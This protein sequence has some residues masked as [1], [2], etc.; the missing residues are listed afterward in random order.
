MRS[1]FI[2]RQL[3]MRLNNP[4]EEYIRGYSLLFDDDPNDEFTDIMVL[5]WDKEE[6]ESHRVD[7]TSPTGEITR[8]FPED[9]KALN[10]GF[11]E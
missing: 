8:I 5:W 11:Y 4:R 7:R 2:S 3:T 9:I 10:K 1:R 6:V